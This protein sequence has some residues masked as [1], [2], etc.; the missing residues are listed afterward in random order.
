MESELYYDLATQDVPADWLDILDNENFYECFDKIDGKD[1][2]PNPRNILNA[3]KLTPFSE[4]KVILIGQ[5]PYPNQSN[6][7]GL[8]FSTPYELQKV[9]QSL[10]KIYEC[11]ITNNHI[12]AK[13]SHGCLENW[14]KQGVLLLNTAL[15]CEVGKS[16]S[17]KN[18]WYPYVVDLI[19][20]IC[21]Q[22]PNLIFMLWGGEAQK[23][24]S[25]IKRCHDS[26]TILKWGHPS[27]MSRVNQSD[28]PKHFKYCNHFNEIN[29]LLEY[30][31]IWDPDYDPYARNVIF[32]DGHCRRNGQIDA[33]AGWGAYAPKN[34]DK[35]QTNI[36]FSKHGP[37]DGDQTNNRAELQAVLEALKLLVKYELHHEPTIIVTDSKY[38]QG[39]IT[40]WMWRR[41][42]IAEHK[43]PDIIGEIRNLME[44]MQHK[45]LPNA[46]HGLFHF[47]GPAPKNWRGVNVLWRPAAHDV[48]APN[49]S[50]ERELYI[51]N[52]VADKLSREETASE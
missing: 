8:C 45:E 7:H 5:D 42:W 38:V 9:P 25:V 35:C 47:G 37:V 31:I 41:N 43:N 24:E 52:D 10:H 27:P 3:F 50:F 46:V 2:C 4:V 16:N 6:A 40:D 14:A 11:L 33:K 29:S 34:F 1:I 20:Q 18:I 39:I 49:D 32:T 21:L 44:L 48:N 23:L 19:T 36:T 26:H 15:T 12:K 51:G 17:H 28:N 30:P 22:K 13:P